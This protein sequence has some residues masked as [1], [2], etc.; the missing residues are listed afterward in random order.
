[1][2]IAKGKVG[3]IS[4]EIIG[5]GKLFDRFCSEIEIFTTESK[6]GQPD[7]RIK[8]G[9]LETA[10]KGYFPKFSSAKNHMTFNQNAF[11]YDEPV[12]FFCKNLFEKG[13]CELFIE[14]TRSVKASVKEALSPKINSCVEVSYSLFWYIIQVLLIK[15]NYSF[16]HAGIISHGKEAT[17]FLGTGGSGKTSII[18]D[19]LSKCKYRYL[20]E[21][22]G[23]ISEEGKALF[24]TKTLS[25]YDS[26]IRRDSSILENVFHKM[27]VQASLKWMIN[28]YIRRRNPMAKIPVQFSFAQNDFSSANLKQAFYIVRTSESSPEVLK[29]DAEELSERL[30]NVTLREMKKLVELLTLISANAPTNYPYPTLEQFILNIKGI[31]RKAFKN[32]D[33]YLLKLPFTSTP[34][35]V[36]EFLHSEDLLN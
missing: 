6:T 31:Y 13:M 23:I 34:R 25:V 11:Y 33:S 7:L 5:S 35:E 15:K 2:K 18:F 10:M 28:K 16:I 29:I 4:I 19:W 8:L 14:N 32:T 22:F 30:V 9:N 21:D 1:M 27:P 26:D 24:S 36:T 3:P 12:P 20:S 17:A